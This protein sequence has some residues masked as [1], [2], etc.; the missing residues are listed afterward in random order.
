MLGVY[1]PNRDEDDKTLRS[2]LRIIEVL[3][4][5]FG[6]LTEMLQVRILPG[7][8]TSYFSGFESEKSLR[9]CAECSELFFDVGSAFA[10]FSSCYDAHFCGMTAGWRQTRRGRHD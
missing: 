3:A 1:D 10:I 2:A 8:P 5:L 4:D 7:E 9:F 6:C